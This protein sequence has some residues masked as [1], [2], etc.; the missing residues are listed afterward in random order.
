MK[1]AIK[2]SALVTLMVGVLGLV[3][4][5]GVR[6]YEKYTTPVELTLRE[7]DGVKYYYT[8]DDDSYYFKKAVKSVTP[9][10]GYKDLVNNQAELTVEWDFD[11][12]FLVTISYER[13]SEYGNTY[14]S[15]V[16]FRSGDPFTEESL[17]SDRFE[18]PS[19]TEY[20]IITEHFTT[21]EELRK[22]VVN[23]ARICK[24]LNGENI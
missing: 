14:H 10:D 1:K 3:V 8:T 7:E 9:S 23:G 2:I 5:V 12:W 24:E 22:L 6:V 16:S 17:F 13:L 20:A 11:Q 21:E 15:R 18:P 4:Y 19:Y